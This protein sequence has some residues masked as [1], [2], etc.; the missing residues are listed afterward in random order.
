MNHAYILKTVRAQLANDLNCSPDDFDREGFVFCEAREN[1]GRRPFPR[2]KRH[3][4]ML[5]MGGAVIVS[6]TPDILP[7]VRQQLQ[8]KTRDEAFE[9]PFA[10]G[11]G[12]NYLPDELPFLRAPDGI[13]I[14]IAERERILEL[15]RLTRQEDFSHA[16]LYN[17]KH[18][19]PDM[20]AAV[21]RADGTIAG[22]A[23]VS[24]DCKALWQ[25]GINVLPEHRRLGIAAYLTNRLA[26]EVLERGKI[27]YYATAV[28]NILSQRVAHRAG[29]APA[30]ATIWRGRFDGELTEPTS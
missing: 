26:A 25:I 28:S 8:G 6:A 4:D 10:V 9:L 27:P 20:L 30:W 21:A 7:Y 11:T 2:G 17:E 13:D 1:P 22:M 19:R 23:G 16:L 24:A 29:F 18:P 14:E 3:L 12:I 5:T 15:Y